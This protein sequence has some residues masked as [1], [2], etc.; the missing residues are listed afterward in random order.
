MVGDDA[1]LRA[2]EFAALLDAVPEMKPLVRAGM[3]IADRRWTLKL[4]NGVDVKLPEEGAAEALAKL[5]FLNQT[6]RVL[7]KDIILVDLRVPGRVA[8]RLTEE[9]ASARKLAFD[10][11]FP[12]KGK[13]PV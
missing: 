5:A 10:K 8:F 3:L 11:K 6:D 13:N 9:A 2:G 4:R 7:S 1:N 12:R